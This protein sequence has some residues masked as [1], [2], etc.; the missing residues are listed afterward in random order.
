MQSLLKTNLSGGLKRLVST[1]ICLMMVLATFPMHMLSNTVFAEEGDEEKSIILSEA[2]EVKA[3][4]SNEFN[5]IHGIYRI[6]ITLGDNITVSGTDSRMSTNY[7]LDFTDPKFAGKT[8]TIAGRPEQQEELE[9][10][11]T[12]YSI[13]INSASLSF[14][15][16]KDCTVILQNIVIDGGS[17]NRST[18][19]IQVDKATEG[20]SSYLFIADVNIQQCNASLASVYVINNAGTLQITSGSLTCNQTDAIYNSGTVTLPEDA[21][22][23]KI[24][25]ATGSAENIASK[26]FKCDTATKPVQVTGKCGST[27]LYGRFIGVYPS[28]ALIEI[29]YVEGYTF[30]QLEYWDG[31]AYV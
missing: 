31:S 6:N 25:V 18:D 28:G 27:S 26:H 9:E 23:F 19:F 10:L 17:G 20:N 15:K 11:P 22:Q 21:S 14:L 1:L 7:F 24:K 13:T 8:I 16:L 2:N 29:P 30:S 12:P 3:W 5:D 4:M